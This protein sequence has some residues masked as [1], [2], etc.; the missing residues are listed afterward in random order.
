MKK[1]YVGMCADFIHHG[2]LN[3][4]QE[5]RKHGKVIVGLLTD[6]TITSYKRSP[7]IS[8]EDRK[9]IIENIKGVYSVIP[10]VTL[11][12][13]KNLLKIKPDYV[14]H[15]DDWATGVQKKIRQE[16]IDTLNKWNGKLIEIPYTDGV[17]STMFHDQ[18]KQIGITPAARMKRLWNLINTKSIVRIIEAH[19]GLTGLIVE[20]LKYNQ[21]EFD[22]MWLSS[23]THSASKGKPDIQYVDITSISQ[24]LSEIF[25]VSTK[26]II[27][28]VDNGGFIEHFKFTVKTLERL[29]VSAIIV[30][31]KIGLKQN[32]LF[33]KQKQS[34]D[35]IDDFSK[36]IYEGKRV[37]VTKDFM[38]IS[39]IESL[40]MNKG[41]EDALIRAHTYIEAG[42]DGIMIHSKNKNPSE[43][44]VFCKKFRAVDKVTPIIV[45]PSTYNSITET[46]LYNEG[47]NVVIYA[48]H[49][50][51]SAYP[52]MIKAAESIL[53]NER[54]FEANEICIPI[55]E[56]LTL[57]PGI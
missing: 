6:K 8:Y 45:V 4:I 38:I 33:E 17:S 44:L 13:R 22:G 1:V 19:N 50:L 14:V 31:D 2:H 26:P 49:L 29:G 55:K 24:T 53:K 52:A 7:M 18:T 37:Q 30:E 9:F 5:A 15:G 40:I 43:I 12:Y 48:N 35:S 25:E 57:I 47:V 16:V 10:Q 56:I 20:N 23:L 27:V 28:D 46:E 11:S 51:R 41:I 54:S 39:R 32:S 42:T 34:Q 36:K 3:I 21:K